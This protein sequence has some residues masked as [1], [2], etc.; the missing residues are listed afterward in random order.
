MIVAISVVCEMNDWSTPRPAVPN[1]SDP[2]ENGSEIAGS[3]STNKM[4]FGFTGPAIEGNV[5]APHGLPTAFT[6]AF[7]GLALRLGARCR[8][9]TS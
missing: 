9:C 7:I 3:S 8:R 4:R 5:A 6:E 1:Q 2:F